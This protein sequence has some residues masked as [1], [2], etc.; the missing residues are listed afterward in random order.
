MS[1]HRIFTPDIHAETGV[2]L[3]IGGQEAHH[4]VRVKRVKAGDPLE[5]LDGRGLRAGAVV[6]AT[7]KE[8]GE[9]GRPEW[10]VRVRVERAEVE[11]P[12]RPRLHVLACAPKLTRVEDMVDQLSQVGAAAWTPLVTKHT[13]APPRAGKMG[14]LER[15]AAEAA[16]QCGRAWVMEVGDPMEFREAI[17]R[18]ALGGGARLV[19]A[20]PAGAPYRA[21]GSEE[22]GLLIGPEA[23]FT[24]GEVEAARGAGADVCRIGPHLMRVGTAA[25]VASGIILDA[26][27]ARAVGGARGGGT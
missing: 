15:V 11:P 18:R 16:K 7:V 14:K 5:I 12:T 25:V 21:D 17:A 1:V 9:R 13:V 2:E 4:A 10:V 8:P 3:V 20:D 19:I 24:E 6:V 23:G 22:I 26:E 27:Y